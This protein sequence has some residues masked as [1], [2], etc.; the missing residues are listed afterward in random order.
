[1]K[2]YKNGANVLKNRRNLEW[3]IGKN[4]GLVKSFPTSIYLQNLGSKQ[5]RTTLRKGSKNACSKGPRW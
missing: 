5:P 1:M 4:V 2:L 3:C